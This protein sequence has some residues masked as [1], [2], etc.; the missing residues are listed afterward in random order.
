MLSPVALNRISPKLRATSG[1]S[2]HEPPPGGRRGGHE[3]PVYRQ[4]IRRMG[5]DCCRVAWTLPQTSAR[6]SKTRPWPKAGFW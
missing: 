1:N 5:F 6:V 2:S 4:D 3:N